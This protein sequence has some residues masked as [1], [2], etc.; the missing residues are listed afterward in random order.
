MYKHIDLG[1]WSKDLDK[2]VPETVCGT[3]DQTPKSSPGRDSIHFDMT[4]RS[5]A[6]DNRNSA[7]KFD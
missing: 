5:D 2:I 1:D 3:D 4:V 7:S 6:Q